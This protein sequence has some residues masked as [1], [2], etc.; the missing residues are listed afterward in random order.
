MR[1]HAATASGGKAA[2]GAWDAAACIAMSLVSLVAL[3]A[4]F[5]GGRS[6]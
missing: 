3:N 4:T 6:V 1:E 2:R 5:A